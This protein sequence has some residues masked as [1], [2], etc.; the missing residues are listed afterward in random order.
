MG[1][2]IFVRNEGGAVRSLLRQ[3][4]V[5]GKLEHYRHFREDLDPHVER[6]K[7]I[8]KNS[9]LGKDFR[10]E[11]SVPRIVIDD[12]LRK[13]DKNWNDWATDAELKAKFLAWFKNDYSKLAASTHRERSLA[14]NR[15]TAPRLGAK[16][17]ADYRSQ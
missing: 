10:Y 12:W 6:V 3:Y 15:A 9:P 1:R 5:S 16:I 8:A 14:V 13:Q 2:E 7:Q 11:G 4:G 17:L